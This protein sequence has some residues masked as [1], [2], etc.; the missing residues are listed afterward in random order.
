[1]KIFRLRFFVALA[2]L[3]I[4]NSSNAVVLE[5]RV[6]SDFPEAVCNSG[7]PASVFFKKGASGRLALLISGG[8]GARSGSG[9]LRRIGIAERYT[10]SDLTRSMVA[11]LGYQTYDQKAALFEFFDQRGDSIIW[12]PYCSSDVFMGNHTHQ[13]NGVEV[14]FKGQKIFEA[15]IQTF[16]K[17]INEAKQWVIG[18]FSAGSIAI[19]ANLKLI[20]QIN[21]P[22]VA[23]IFDGYW[24]N[25]SELAF[26]KKIGP[27]NATLAFIS[28]GLPQ[29]CES[30]ATCYPSRERI[31]KYGMK[32]AFITWNPGDH[33]RLTKADQPMM[34]ETEKD[35]EL[36][37]GGITVSRQTVL[38]ARIGNN[39]TAHCVL[40][41]DAFHQVIDGQSVA[42]V[43]AHWLDKTGGKTA[44]VRKD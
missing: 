22:N 37:G 30:W 19:G 33:Y 9:Y 14:P 25:E 15:V 2:C 16:G 29:D 44:I 41:T 36:F 20:H 21:H 3:I 40:F 27:S 26:R 6:L 10:G 5:G 12:L 34:D 35:I 11:D 23:L 8:G 38:T 4:I 1:M 32:R 18:G 7:A 17:E 42:N 43:F 39:N 28:K 31:E 13:I 24:L